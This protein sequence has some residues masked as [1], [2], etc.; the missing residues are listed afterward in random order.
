MRATRT[1]VV[2]CV[3]WL[4]LA[5]PAEGQEPPIM[6]EQEAVQ[7]LSSSDWRAHDRAL[8]FAWRL[9]SEAGAELRVA[10]VKAAME[11]VRGEIKRGNAE[12]HYEAVFFYGDV[13]AALREPRA[14][15]FFLEIIGGSSGATNALADIGSAALPSVLSIVTDSSNPYYAV[16]GALTALRFMV[17]DGWPGPE[18]L[19]AI[20]E[21]ARDCLTGKQ[22]YW[23]IRQ[24]LFLAVALGDPEL[25]AIVATLASDRSAVEALI[26][27]DDDSNRE[28]SIENI[29]KD[30]RGLLS[31]T[32]VPFPERR[33][34]SEG[35]RLSRLGSSFQK[36]V[37]LRQ[38]AP[39]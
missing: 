19:A 38:E 10:L 25:L 7:A 1:V 15:P 5:V 29:Q 18:E 28:R 30:A 35:G 20:R 27:G 34:W 32:L 11:E 9:G 33:P 21:A 6:T 13:L 3:A 14:V 23:T 4:A 12:S 26:G 8:S 16:G 22:D 39:R 17:E 24:A 31:G 36:R 37:T 2:V